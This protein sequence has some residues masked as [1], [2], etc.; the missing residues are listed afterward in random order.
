MVHKKMIQHHL[1]LLEQVPVDF[2]EHQDQEQ[3]YGFVLKIDFHNEQLL[4]L[5]I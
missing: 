1:Q 3:H 5:L 2:Q 4:L